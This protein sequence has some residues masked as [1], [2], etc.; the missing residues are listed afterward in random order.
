MRQKK[1][2][3]TARL[4]LIAAVLTF[5]TGTFIGVA[6]ARSYPEEW[7]LGDRLLAGMLFFIALGWVAGAYAVLFINTAPLIKRL[8]LYPLLKIVGTDGERKSLVT[9]K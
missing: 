2:S 9:K 3:W 1:L 4:F 6:S 7:I 8:S 5:G